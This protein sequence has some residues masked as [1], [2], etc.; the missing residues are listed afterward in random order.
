MVYI[1]RLQNNSISISLN[2]IQVNRFPKDGLIR[3]HPRI[4]CCDLISGIPLET[5]CP[6]N[7]SK[8]TSVPVARN[9]STKCT[10]EDFL[11]CRLVVMTAISSN[12]FRE[13]QDMIAGV[14]ANLPYTHLI[15]YDLGLSIGEKTQLSKYCNVEVRPLDFSKYPL[16]VEKLETFAWKPIITSEIT[17][18]YEIVMYGDASLR[19]FQHATENLLPFLLEFPFVSGPTGKQPIA[20]MTHDST[21]NY[22]GLNMPRAM[23]V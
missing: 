15:V 12:H 4:F 21:L 13:A 3:P 11:Y 18:E 23:A 19:I 20:A 17:R 6:S 1:H 5:I 10:C 9:N 8:T 16:H 2:I 7:V 14:Q 22:L